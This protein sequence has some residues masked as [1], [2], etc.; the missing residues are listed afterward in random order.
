MK[1]DAGVKNDRCDPATL[2]V[3]TGAAK[4]IGVYERRIAEQSRQLQELS[5]EHRRFADLSNDLEV[6]REHIGIQAQDYVD[7]FEIFEKKCVECAFL[8]RT[9]DALR[10]EHETM[11][12]R[13]RM[14]TKFIAELRRDLE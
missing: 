8:K 3:I 12:I 9:L 13:I 14:A 1:L 11:E 7:L 2:E 10:T 6:L 4:L 5:E